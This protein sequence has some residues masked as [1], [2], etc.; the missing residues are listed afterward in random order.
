MSNTRFAIALVIAVLADTVGLPFGEF[1]V[2]VFDVFV[3]LLLTICLG[4]RW[5]ILVACIAEAIPGV[6][7]FPCWAA[8]VPTIWYLNRKP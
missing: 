4:P 1:G 5:L 8:A 3:A 6:G 7:L 2:V